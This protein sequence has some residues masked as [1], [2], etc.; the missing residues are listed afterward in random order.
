MAWP[1]DLD[2]VEGFFK[3]SSGVHQPNVYLNINQTRLINQSLPIYALDRDIRR[4]AMRTLEQCGL[5]PATSGQAALSFLVPS[6]YPSTIPGYDPGISGPVWELLSKEHHS[7][8]R[9]AD[10]LTFWSR[11]LY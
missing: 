8:P 2:V 3:L 7:L 9:Y 6:E 11:F 1:I 5:R 10:S 4:S